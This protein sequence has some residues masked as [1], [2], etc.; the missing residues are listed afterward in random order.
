MLESLVSKGWYCFDELFS[1]DFCFNISNELNA[2]YNKGL[3]DEAAIG[4]ALKHTVKSNI[5]DSQIL[6][7]D[8]WSSLELN[9][10]HAFTTELMEKLKHTLLLSLKRFE[11]QF[12]VYEPGGFYK[13]HLDQL[14]GSGHRQ[15]STILYLND[16]NDGGE[17]VLYNKDNK[18][19]ID[20]LISPR[21]GQ[22]VIFI[23]SQIFHEVKPT[24]NQRYSLTSWL[25]DDEIIPLV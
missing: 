3:F 4:R 17:L 11:S 9:Q 13:K 1:D 6:W 19:I 20:K 22:F 14:K 15:I 10:F 2:K 5:R 21:S 23:S 25:R 12:A 7:I 18:N 24:L 8:D 16:C